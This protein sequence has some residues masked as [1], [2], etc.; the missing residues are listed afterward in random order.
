[1]NEK[2]LIMWMKNISEIWEL[3]R[4]NS[5]NR[6]LKSVWKNN[7]KVWKKEKKNSEFCKWKKSMNSVN[8]K[9]E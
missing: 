1:M 3:K 4:V 7:W 5:I 9:S 2:K 8:E 6:K